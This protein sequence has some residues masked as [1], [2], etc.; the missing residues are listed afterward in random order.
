[1]EPAPLNGTWTLRVVRCPRMMIFEP[2]GKKPVNPSEAVNKF[3]LLW[4]RCPA[5][6]DNTQMIPSPLAPETHT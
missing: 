2:Y 4:P 5:N 6:R 1:V 3:R